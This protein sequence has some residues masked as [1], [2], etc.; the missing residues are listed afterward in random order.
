MT[1][2]PDTLVE[3]AILT[4]SKYLG[5]AAEFIDAQFGKGYAKAHPEL[6]GAFVQT[7]AL[8]FAACALSD[9]LSEL[10][11]AVGRAES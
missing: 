9:C 5:A 2:S 6:I 7:C 3:Q 11:E 8:D 10:A 1:S 4:T